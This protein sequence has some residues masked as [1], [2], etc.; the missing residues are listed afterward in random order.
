MQ[1]IT[2]KQNMSIKIICGIISF[3]DY[4]K[5]RLKQSIKQKFKG[6]L[7]YGMV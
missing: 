2:S 6:E 7:Q 4:A 5:S 1:I 3:L